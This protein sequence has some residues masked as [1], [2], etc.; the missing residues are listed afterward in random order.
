MGLDDL[1][2]NH[3]PRP[4]FCPKPCS[5]SIRVKALKNL[6]ERFG[7]NARSVIVDQNLDLA[8]EPAARNA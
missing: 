1:F 6:A 4:E 3:R 7:S 8:F 2:G 5:C